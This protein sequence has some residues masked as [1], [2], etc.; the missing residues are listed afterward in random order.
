MVQRNLGNATTR[1]E[2]FLRKQIS[3]IAVG[4]KTVARI[5]FVYPDFESIGIEYLMAICINEGHDVNF[6]YYHVEDISLGMKNEHISF[7]SIAQ[8]I[9]DTQPHIV[10]FSCVTDNYQ[11][12]LGCARAIKE[13]RPTVATIF[14]GIH[15]STVPELVL[16]NPEVDCVAIGEAEKSFSAFINKC[17]VHNNVLILPDKPIKGIA[18]KRGEEAYR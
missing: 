2:V 4:G 3:Q 10:A 15:P 9:A 12:Q 16:R 1:V 5:T 7:Q 18:H 8:K 14:G 13:I 11:S 17:R 6:V